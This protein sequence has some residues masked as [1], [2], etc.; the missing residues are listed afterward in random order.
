MGLARR[1]VR[2]GIPPHPYDTWD[3][4]VLLLKAYQVLNLVPGLVRIV[5]QKVQCNVYC[6]PMPEGRTIAIAG[7]DI[8]PWIWQHAPGPE[9]A[10]SMKHFHII[11]HWPPFTFTVIHDFPPHKP[12]GRDTDS[13]HPYPSLRSAIS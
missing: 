2:R 11:K 10:F 13:C 1:P 5:F 7:A 4:T 6:I 12:A 3:H 8:L 9:L